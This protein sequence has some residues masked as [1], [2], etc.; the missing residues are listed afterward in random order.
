MKIR[1]SKEQKKELQSS[2]LK[3]KTTDFSQAGEIGSDSAKLRTATQ[4]PSIKRDKAKSHFFAT[5]K[6]RQT[7]KILTL[8][9]LLKVVDSNSKPTA[10]GFF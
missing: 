8:L 10:I 4:T 9:L 1:C 3:V 2:Y 7:W 6:K 5:L